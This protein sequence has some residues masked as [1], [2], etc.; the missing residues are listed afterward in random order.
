MKKLFKCAQIL[1]NNW[2]LKLGRL[3]EEMLL[4]TPLLHLI[5]KR[6]EQ[7]KMLITFVNINNL[8]FLKLFN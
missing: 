2:R 1:S 8:I 3:A 7:G 5:G 4:T 6:N